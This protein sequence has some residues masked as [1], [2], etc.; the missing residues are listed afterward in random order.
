[1]SRTDFEALPT[2]IDVREVHLLIQQPGFRPKE[3]VL[4]TTLVDP[5]RY[6]KAKARRTLP[7]AL[8]SNGNQSQAS[9]NHLKDGDDCCQ[10]PRNGAKGNLGAFAWVQ[11]AAKFDVAIGAAIAGVALADVLAG[12]STTVQSVQTGVGSDKRPKPLSPLLN[13]APCHQ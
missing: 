8:F 7:T 10:N 1:M 5:K 12:N 4:V 2:S 3:I 9:Q 6:P 11:L 13:P